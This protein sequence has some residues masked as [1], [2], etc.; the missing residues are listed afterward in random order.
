M[1]TCIHVYVYVC[2]Y[3]YVCVC[4]YMY[5]YIYLFIHTLTAP[6]LEGRVLG[7]CSSLPGQAPAINNVSSNVMLA[8]ICC[9]IL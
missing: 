3:V 2:I 1:Y 8:L 4:T 5:I 6:R 7:R 9:I